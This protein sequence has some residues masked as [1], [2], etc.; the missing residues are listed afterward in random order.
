MM[1][2]ARKR[3]WGMRGYNLSPIRKRKPC[4]RAWGSLKSGRKLE[5]AV[6]L[7]LPVVDPDEEEKPLSCRSGS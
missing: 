4:T 6:T 7:K 3:S 5:A 1:R 2:A